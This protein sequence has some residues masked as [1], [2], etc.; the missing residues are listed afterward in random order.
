M[1][2]FRDKFGGLTV[3]QALELNKAAKWF[4]E[5]DITSE[6]EDGNMKLRNKKTGGLA[7]IDEL[8]VHTDAGFHDYSSLAEL[9]EEWEDAPE[10]PKEYWYIGNGGAVHGFNDYYVATEIEEAYREIGNLFETKEEAEKAVEKLKAWK[11]LKDK[12]FRFDPVDRYEALC[13][14][15]FNIPITATMPPEA[16]TDAEVSKDLDLLFGGEEI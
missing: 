3:E 8:C 5:H 1:T 13:G 2:C 10:E 6:S 7:N 16:Y 11:R 9:N 15:G 4:C 14:N 12:G